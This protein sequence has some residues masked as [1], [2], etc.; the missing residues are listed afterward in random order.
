MKDRPFAL[1]GVNS[2]KNLEEIR[3]IVVEKS[4]NW[5]SFQNKPDGAKVAI[6]QDWAV[7]GWPTLVVLDEE[8][9]IVYRGHDG[10]EA[11]AKA[12]SLVD[13]LEQKK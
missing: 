6:S 11:V 2:D 3:K 8:M 9:R 4:I 1:V 7:K 5:R 10:D 13:A 12:K